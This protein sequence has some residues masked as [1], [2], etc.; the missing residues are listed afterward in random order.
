MRLLRAVGI[1]AFAAVL[2]SCGGG[3]PVGP[4][5][6][7]TPI[8]SSITP[9]SGP[10]AGGTSVRIAGANFSAGASVT[11]GG[12]LAT[13]VVVEAAWSIA[14]TTGAHA[15]GPADVAVTA[16][17]R[18]GSLPAAFTYEASNPPVISTITVRGAKPNEPANFADV[19]EE[20]IVTA[21]VQDPD[22]PA[23]QLT[24]EWSADAGTFTGT[25]ASVKWRAPA[26]LPAGTVTLTM[27]LALTVSDGTRVSA[28][29]SVSVHDSIKEVGDLARLFLLEFSDSNKSPEFVVRN[30]STSAR[31]K[32]GRDSEFSDVTKNR[33]FYRIESSSIGPASVTVQFASKPC[34]FGPLDGDACAVVPV[35]WNSLCLKTN[36]ECTAGE[37]G[38]ADGKDYVTAVFE[39]SDWR[40]CASNFEPRDGIFRPNFIR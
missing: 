1:A 13:S 9:S 19:G 35:V 29:A 36:S 24:Y 15:A 20:I 14:A 3:S 27:T 7:A 30:F 16:G 40:L 23:D 21:T 38:R 22:T 10:A 17:G 5:G 6:P 18:T 33:R 32:G 39:G 4:T 12:V 2:G 26:S 28:K 31:C 37:R 11:I 34:T 25:G 8:V